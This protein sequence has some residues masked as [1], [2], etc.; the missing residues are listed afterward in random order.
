MS[1]YILRISGD[2]EK[3]DCEKCPIANINYSDFVCVVDKEVCPLEEVKQGI[4][5]IIT[6]LYIPTGVH[7]D[8]AVRCGSCDAFICYPTELDIEEEYRFCRKCGEKID[9]SKE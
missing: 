2:F 6:P 7:I 1:K 3:G 9:W 5:P 4:K 8:D